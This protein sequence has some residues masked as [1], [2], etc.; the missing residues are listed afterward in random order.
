M[1]YGPLPR[2]SPP[3]CLA[4]SC[5]RPAASGKLQG[6]LTALESPLTDWIY[7]DLSDP[8]RYDRA[9]LELRFLTPEQIETL[10]KTPL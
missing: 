10:E 7:R 4:V 1:A 2:S 9:K 3:P 5:S 6:V 8:D